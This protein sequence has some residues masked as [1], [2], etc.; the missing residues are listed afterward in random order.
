M[1][2]QQHWNLIN[3][4]DPR[5]WNLAKHRSAKALASMSTNKRE[6]ANE[7]QY[8]FKKTGDRYYLELSKRLKQ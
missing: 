6:L 5:I 2:E 4:E 8:L 7:F 1:N 3:S